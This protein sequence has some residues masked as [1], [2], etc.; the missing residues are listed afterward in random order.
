MVDGFPVLLKLKDTVVNVIAVIHG[1]VTVHRLGSPY[2]GWDV[3][4]KRRRNRWARKEGRGQE[5][6][7]GRQERAGRRRKIGVWIVIEKGG[8]SSLGIQETYHQW[9]MPEQGQERSGPGL[10]QQKKV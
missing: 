8:V 1:D 10:R 9:L 6:Q 3:N 2:F 7:R 5:G 4:N